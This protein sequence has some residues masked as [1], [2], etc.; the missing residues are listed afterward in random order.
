MVDKLKIKQK[1]GG[2]SEDEMEKDNP[3]Q[4]VALVFVD[5]IMGLELYK[6]CVTNKINLSILENGTGIR[7]DR[8]YVYRTFINDIS[9]L[10][11]DYNLI[12]VSRVRCNSKRLTSWHEK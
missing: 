12:Q 2:E 8:V 11:V 4:T 6:L 1:L 10:L 5:M 3:Q 9:A 7:E